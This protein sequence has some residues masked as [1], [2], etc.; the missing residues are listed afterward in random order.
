MIAAHYRDGP[1]FTRDV[2]MFHLNLKVPKQIDIAVSGGTDSMAVLDFFSK[3]KRDIR[4]LY[5]NHKT[6]NSKDA[7]DLIID[8]CESK[9]IPYKIGSIQDTQNNTVYE[10]GLENYW[11]KSRYKFFET[12]TRSYLV[13]AHHLNDQVENWLMTSLI[14][15]PEL[16]PAVRN[17]TEDKIL[18]RPFLLNKKNKFKEYCERN[19]VPYTIDPSNEDLSFKRNYTRHVIIPTCLK[20]YPGLE[21]T[22]R[23]MQLK[24]KAT[25]EQ[26]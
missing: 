26:Y 21:T 7:Q 14:G 9:N 10:Y 23:N 1:L 3:S 18:L 17:L 15:R 24:Q 8:Y 25:Y 6:K 5:F 16:I 19:N 2:V 20:Q 22:I 4:A 11:R 13:M 12:E